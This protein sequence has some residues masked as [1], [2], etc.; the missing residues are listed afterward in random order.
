VEDI[1]LAKPMQYTEKVAKFT[2]SDF[3]K[4]FAK[5]GLKI[6]EVFGDYQFAEYNTTNSPRLIMIAEKI[7][8]S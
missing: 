4:M 8:R 1:A 5:Q 6:K 2:L 7:A 3:E